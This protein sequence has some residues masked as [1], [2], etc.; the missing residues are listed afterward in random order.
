[1]NPEQVFAPGAWLTELGGPRYIQLKRRIE[2]AIENRLL[3]PGA[4]LPPERELARMTGLSRVTVRKAVAPL[5]AA[6]LIEQRRGSGTSVAR[7]RPR[8]EQSLSRLTSFSEDMA[9]R[10]ASASS[11]WLTRGVFLP[12][13]EETM[14][15]GLAADQSVSRLERLRLADA[16]PMA[17]ERAALSSAILPDPLEVEDSLYDLLARR[18]KRPVRALQRIRAANI[19]EQD[20]TLLALEPGDAALMITRISYLASG[21]IAEFTRSIYRGD[22]YDFVAELTLPQPGPG[23]IP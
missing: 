10:G 20:A 6:G 5:V 11:V 7:A 16:T 15:L 12:S 3:A 22:S 18:G 1:M 21:Q 8:V 17:I 23:Q 19:S 9:R 14:G 13:P 4:P 2:S